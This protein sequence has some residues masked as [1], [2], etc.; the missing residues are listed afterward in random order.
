MIDFR[1]IAEDSKRVNE[2]K[3]KFPQEKLQQLWTAAE[4][5]A[6][7]LS[8]TSASPGH[9]NYGAGVQ[10]YHLDENDVLY[11]PVK[12]WRKLPGRIT[13]ETRFYINGYIQ[14]IDRSQEN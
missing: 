2:A 9:G 6:L 1:E 4:K 10:G 11:V 14:I 13:A 5:Y 3:A 7:F 8:D 12:F